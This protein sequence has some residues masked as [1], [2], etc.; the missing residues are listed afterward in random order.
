YVFDATAPSGQR[1]D[2][3]APCPQYEIAPA[4]ALAVS[5]K[6]R[7]D[8]QRFAELAGQNFQLA[9]AYVPQNGRV[10]RALGE[11]ARPATMM[12]AAQPAETTTQG[13]AATQTAAAST[14][15]LAMAPADRV[16][17]NMPAPSPYN[18]T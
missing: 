11:P 1:F 4:I 6:Q 18:R 8:E 13:R 3:N 12:A 9:E 2:P 10:R 17:P 14:T 5:G 16:Q 7:N 15:A